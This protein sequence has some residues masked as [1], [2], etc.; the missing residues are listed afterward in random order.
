MIDNLSQGAGTPFDQVLL[1]LP[2]VAADSKGS[3]SLHVRDDHGNVQYRVNGVQLPEGITGFGQ[4]FDTRIVD[5]VDFMTGALP[6]QFGLRTAGIVDI[7]T[8]EGG[9]PGGSL[10]VL[11]GGHD[12]VE[13]SAQFFGS[14]GAFNYYLS[15]S[16][17][18]NSLGIE[19]PQPTYS[20]IHDRTRQTKSFGNLSYY[21]DD[22][23]RVGLM[24]GSYNGRFQIP[25]NPG[26]APAFS[27]TGVS[28]AAAGTSILPSDRLDDN[29]REIN[30]FVVLSLQ[31]SLGDLSY[32][33]SGFHQYS[34]LHFTPD[35]AGDLSYLG[36]AS[37]SLR[38]NSANGVQ[39]DM[40]YKLH[41][42]HTLR[43][44]L[45]YTRQ[46]TESN[47]A[48]SVFPTDDSGAQTSTDPIVINDNNR[49]TGRLA[50]FYVQD[51]WRIVPRLTLNYGL[52]F[53][54][55]SAFIDE[56]Q[57]SP[58]LNLAYKLSEATAVHAGYSRYFTPPPQE[59]VAQSSINLYANTSNAP[60][61]ATS[62]PVKAERTHYYDVGISHQINPR[63]TVTADAFY[64][65]V[66]NL[67][68]EGQFGQAL[69]LTPFN[70]EKGYAKGLELSAVYSE[71]S[72]GAY[73]NATLQKAEGSN[74]VSSQSLFGADELAYI[75][76]HYI[77]LDHD[78]TLTL[79]G[80]AHYH[81]GNSQVSADFVHG[82][83]LRRTPDG[84]APNSG[85]LPQ[86]TTVNTAFTHN[87][88]GTQVGDLEGRI[89][90][91]N[92]FDKTYQLR[93]GSG[94]GVGAPQFGPRRTLYVGLSTRF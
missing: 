82:S 16:Y 81:F 3:G 12:Y 40:S 44:G 50:S 4:S 90:L 2:G 61:I 15:G 10:G 5:Q 11:V 86:Y 33:V 47:N 28:D 18:S 20:A 52:R 80:G 69:I 13:P 94:V 32:Q 46:T 48:V 8:K 91:V 83:G 84:D 92:L 72:W 73:L 79:S 77:Y 63:L 31:K 17:L 64:K 26:Q 65:K 37:D 45:A 42:D 58:R 7:Q 78:Q 39:F 25:N 43:A 6:A 51:E 74:I 22:N 38:S 89:A 87:W 24:F 19:N 55:V 1:H 9:K 34:E 68:D 36:V 59:L 54:K 60:E 57:W 93:D 41:K 67:L 53:D 76:N 23:T 49:K 14:K 21:L 30:R 35:V 75:A 71:K 85:R 56:Q 29:Q 70:Y 66:T 62:D 27:L 88:K